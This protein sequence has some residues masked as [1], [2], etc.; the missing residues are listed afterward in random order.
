MWIGAPS[1][2]V[3]LLQ[4]S[5]SLIASPQRLPLIARVCVS[6]ERVL[7]RSSDSQVETGGGRCARV[8]AIGPG[9]PGVRVAQRWVLV[10]SVRGPRE[11]RAHRGGAAAG[12]LFRQNRTQQ[13]RR[14]HRGRSGRGAH[15]R[16]AARVAHV[17]PAY[18]CGSYATSRQSGQDHQEP[19]CELIPYISEFDRATELKKSERSGKLCKP[20]GSRVLYTRPRKLGRAKS[21]NIKGHHQPAP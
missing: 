9:D 18:G 4:A 12:E 8:D 6:P 16:R 13:W 3:V 11:L 20:I 14:S 5:A 17:W 15:R 7:G 21:S 19:L 2:P 10:G 1:I